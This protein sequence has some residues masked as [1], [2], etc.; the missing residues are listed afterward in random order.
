MSRHDVIPRLLLCCG[1]LLPALASATNGYF[2]H[3]WGGRSSAL[4][5]AG[6]ALDGDAM[7]TATNPAALAGIAGNELQLGVSLIR[8]WPGYSAGTFTPPATPLP[9]GAF[10]L[11]PG[12]FE[13]AADTPGSLFVIPQGAV[14]WR[15]DPHS[16][17]GLAVY[18]NGGLNATY[19]DFDNPACPAGTAQAGTYCGGRAASDLGQVFFAP[20]YARQLHER[21]RLGAS[22]ILALQWFD[23]EGLSAFAPLSSRPDRLSDNGHEFSVGYGL[24]LGLQV[25]VTDTLVLALAGQ[26]RIETTPLKKYE[27]LIADGGRFDIPPYVTAGLAWQAHPRLTA[28]V[29]I[30]HIRFRAIPALGNR[31]QSAAPLG[32]RDGPGFGWT[33]V[34]VHKVGAEFIASPKWTLRAGYSNNRDPIQSDQLFFNLLA[35]SV[36]QEHYTAGLSHRLTAD[37]HLNFAA[38]YAP[39]RVRRGINA[40]FP[41][42]SME[43]ELEGLILDVSWQRR[44]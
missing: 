42:Q 16:A 36:A 21:L 23:I 14:A 15:I 9:P 6:V 13:A 25:D 24:K 44:F 27:G 33:N 3:G 41:D 37:S 18:A 31:V 17:A 1:L 40:F 4:G 12:R 39:R 19:D 5:G 30:Q 8:A 10:P 22:L 28:V 7:L 34:T 2:P 38:M 35:G 29:D 11:R 32:T 20:S 43:V 26:T